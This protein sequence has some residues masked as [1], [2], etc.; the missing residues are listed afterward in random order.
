M[1]IQERI[2][3]AGDMDPTIHLVRA[4]AEVRADSAWPKLAQLASDP[5]F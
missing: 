4:V 3:D 1:N 5:Q 2:E